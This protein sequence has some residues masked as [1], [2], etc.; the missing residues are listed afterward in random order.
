M[1]ALLHAESLCLLRGDRC[2]FRGLGFSLREG[3]LLVIEGPNGSGKTSLLRGIAG[4]LEFEDGEVSWRGQP[5]REN[6]H[7]FRSNLAWFA[8]RV[9]FKGDLT[10][11]E[12][13][14]F[15]AGLRAT[16][17]TKLDAVLTQLELS[18]LVSLPFR[19]LS[20][21]QQRRVSLARMLLSTGRLWIMDEPFTNLD[22][23]GQSLVV[24][25]IE[26][27]LTDGGACIVASHQHIDIDGSTRRVELQ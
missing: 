15:E 12:N 26:R 25:L 17:T 24:E 16:D 21:G 19:S 6:F 11:L 22:A 23:G 1:S 20:A 5:L 8:H 14:A 9:G 27:H 13:L 3:E 10:L 2:L 4:L 18:K 7:D